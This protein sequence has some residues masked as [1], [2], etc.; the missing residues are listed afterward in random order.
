[1][2]D[3]EVTF[4]AEAVTSALESAE[5]GVAEVEL[6]PGSEE[7]RIYQVQVVPPPDSQV[8][9][10]FALAGPVGIVGSGQVL[11]AVTLSR[12]AAL[13]GFAVTAIGDPVASAPVQ[14]GAS[15][16]LRLQVDSEE[17]DAILAQLQFPTATTDEDGLFLVWDDRE[18]A[19]E[20]A[21][22]DVDVSPA[23]FSSD[24]PSWTFE[25]IGVPAEGESVDLGQLVL[26]EASYA[27]G[28][29][30]DRRDRPVIG[31]E[32][33]IYQLGADDYCTR[34]L[35][36]GDADCVPPAHLRGIWASDDSGAVK[37]VL[38]DP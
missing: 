9:S 32:V 11:Q 37:V 13:T 31:A 27:R 23:P 19:G 12:R 6:Y 24:A 7:N 10:A 16:S 25:D 22:Y 4:T 14:A 38:P 30:R 35:D 5:P 3:I 2:R 18:L 29:V 8:Q 17:V 33:R 15:S 36:I 1:M 34:V 20:A 21:T 28:L 26:P